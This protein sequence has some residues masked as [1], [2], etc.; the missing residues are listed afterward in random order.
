MGRNVEPL[1]FV[2]HSDFFVDLGDP[3]PLDV[4]G[5]RVEGAHAARHFQLMGIAGMDGLIEPDLHL[6]P[7]HHR[8]PGEQ[9]L[10]IAPPDIA[11]VCVGRAQILRHGRGAQHAGQSRGARRDHSQLHH[12]APR[13]RRFVRH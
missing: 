2:A 12:C 8:L 10:R 3:V 11:H 9:P 6:A 7:A 13:Q 4:P 1:F 5:Q